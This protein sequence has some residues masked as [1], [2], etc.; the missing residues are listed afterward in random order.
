MADS[1]AALERKAAIYERMAAG[2]D[3]DEADAYNVDFFTKAGNL[4]DEATRLAREAQHRAARPHSEGDA[5]WATGA[6]P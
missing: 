2:V 4:D 1:R 5:A 6:F 3:D